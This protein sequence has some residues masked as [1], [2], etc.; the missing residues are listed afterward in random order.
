[1]RARL[2]LWAGVGAACIIVAVADAKAGGGVAVHEGESPPLWSRSKS[3][4][5]RRQDP[6]CADNALT[7]VRSSSCAAS[8]SPPYCTCTET[9]GL[10]T[11]Q[12]R[13][14]RRA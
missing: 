6:G 3:I 9:I 1:M 2:L 5:S 14:S 11:A 4:K 12:E 7:N 13:S 8:G 10:I